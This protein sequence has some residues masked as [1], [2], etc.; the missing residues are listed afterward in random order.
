[1][2]GPLTDFQ[3]KVEF[4]LVQIIIAA[5]IK[6]FVSDI[7]ILAMCDS[8]FF[9]GNTWKYAQVFRAESAIQQSR[10]SYPIYLLLL[11]LSY[12]NEEKLALREY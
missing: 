3:N 4:N 7:Y 12:S 8:S 5:S 10:V 1:M 2:Y 11:S 9:E 6:V